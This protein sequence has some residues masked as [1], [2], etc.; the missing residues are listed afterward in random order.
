MKTL[1]LYGSAHTD[2]DCAA[3]MNE[4][5]SK[6]CSEY[7]IVDCYSDNISP[8]TDCRFCRSFLQCSIDDDMQEIYDYLTECDNVVIISPV[9][10]GELSAMMLKVSSR[11][12]MYCSASI[13]RKETIP[14]KVKRGAVI[15]AQGGSGGADKAYDTAKQVFFS[16]GITDVYPMICSDNTDRIPA[17]DDTKVF[18]EIDKLARWLVRDECVS[19]VCFSDS[20][21]TRESSPQEKID[22][23]CSLFK[24]REDVYALRY[25]N[26]TTGKSGYT[27]KCANRW[28]PGICNIKVKCPEC[29]N[30]Q[31]V[32][33][34]YKAIYDHLSGKDALCRDVVGIYPMLLDETVWFLAIDFDDGDWQKDI[35]VVRKICDENGVPCSVERSRSGKGGHLWLFFESPISAAKA[36]KLGS[37]LLTCAMNERHELKFS[38]YDRMLPNQDTMPKG[39]FGNLIA[40]PLQKQA[41]KNGN[42]VFV[43]HDFLPYADQWAYLSQV[44]KLDEDSVDAIIQRLG[45]DSELG[46][47]YDEN[48]QQKPWEQTVI[49]TPDLQ[50]PENIEI[51][52]A[53][54]LYIPKANLPQ[55]ALAR[56]KRLACF[57]NPE[58]YKAQ[59]MR[60]STYGKP[61]IICCAQENDE[62]IMLPR[63]CYE[64]LEKLFSEQGCAITLTDKRCI[65]RKIDVEFNGELRQDQNEM[66]SKM[67]QHTDG[68]AAATTAFGKTV[69][70]IGLIAERKVNTLILVH[71]QALMQ[72]WKKELE[73]FLIINEKLPEEPVKRGRKKQRFVVGQLGGS[74]NSLSGIIDI[75]IMQSLISDSEVK[76]V[77]NNYGMV[78]VD[79]CH[80][81]SA[82]SF[83]L[84]LREI[85][86]KYI[87]GLTATPQRSDGHQP[88]IFMQCGPIRYSADAKDYA[89]KHGFE[90]ILIPRFTKFRTEL[91]DEKP[92]IT[93]VYRQLAESEYRNNLIV[94]DVI[95]AVQDGRTPIIIS[96]RMSQ[97]ETLYDMLKDC[98]DNVIVL[99]G[100]GTAKS[101]KECLESVKNVPSS[102]SLILLATGK[103]AGEG[104]D[105]PRLDTLFLALPISWDGKLSQYVGRL[106]RKYDGKSEVV[107]YDYVDI[108]VHMLENMYK[109]RLRGYAKLGY[110]PK[111]VSN[112]G[113]KTIYTDDFE[114][115]LFRDISCAKHYVIVSS[116]YI[117]SGKQFSLIK[118]LEQGKL[119][120]A[121]AVVILKNS[122]NDYH[123]KTVALLSAHDI[124][125]GVK[126][127]LAHSF[128]MI[129]GKTVWYA[130]DSLFGKSD[131]NCVIRVSDEVL[132]GELADSVLN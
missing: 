75:A 2:G 89:A 76:P 73:K 50:L 92:S 66:V 122:D 129:D 124:Q 118:A 113:Y 112:D 68:V 15:L 111:S 35:S 37:C 77:V 65:G 27:P 17:K 83:E 54:M 91:S 108:N 41:V 95:A 34:G 103:Y 100:Q 16:L 96:E 11:F 53:N 52:S 101:K 59:A 72:Q 99:S 42:S 21:V 63:G 64:S 6:I 94:Q 20:V 119:N 8:C 51:V 12:Q 49:E 78:I 120:G 22:L 98:A 29:R 44:K 84:I 7:E 56:I 38:S 115:D 67:M 18:A 58:F 132:A 86:S 30:R 69:A 23:F 90:H 81:V 106:H 107:I 36:R 130:S 80:H 60:M 40:L 71:T 1:I 121:K 87:Y 25:Q 13:F 19:Q 61:R 31:F 88:I 123:H 14:V 85:R 43:D 74:K 46:T 47:L 109:K 62:Y 39:G 26:I 131:D 10:Y 9:H 116:D 5:I 48:E 24:G 114:N 55:K 105:E 4:L 32:K 70:A 3:L 82:V 97:I 57:K 102:E 128:V 117:P 110:A 126:N 33:L 28:R 127:Y 104:F 79:E 93:D 45:A 125:S